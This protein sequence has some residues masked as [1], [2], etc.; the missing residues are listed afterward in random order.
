MPVDLSINSQ[1]T[2]DNS[3]KFI[4]NTVKATGFSRLVAGLSG[5]IDS[6]IS[7]DLAVRALGGKNLYV[8]LLPYGE[9]NKEGT[10]DARVVIKKLGVP[11]ENVFFRDIKPF[12]DPISQ[13]DSSMDKLR[14]GNIAVRL[15]MIILYDLAKKYK[16]LV[17]GTENKT[18]YLLGYFTRFGDEASDIEP[19]RGLYK[20]QLRQLASYLGIPE[21]IIRK[22]PTAGLWT[23]QTDEQELGFSYK[24]AD[25]ILYHYVDFHKSSEEIIR[26]GFKK[27]VVT[28]VI[29]RLQK[30]EF[31]HKLP[32]V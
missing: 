2:T 15:R 18:E 16:A 26:M 20:T 8:A 29:V 3:I 28:R 32:Y 6:A 30:N 24:D 21:K 31:K 4:K 19:I 5:G 12:V 23:G 14:K 11:K 17:L 1:K 10:K 9:L 22:P 25:K 13:L 27:E 7:C